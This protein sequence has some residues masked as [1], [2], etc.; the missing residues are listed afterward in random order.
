MLDQEQIDNWEAKKLSPMDYG[1]VVSGKKLKGS[2][3]VNG[4]LVMVM[5]AKQV[6]ASSKD[7]YVT[8][9]LFTVV[10]MVD[11][12]PAIPKQEND[13]VA[14]L[15]DPRSLEKVVGDE[16]AALKATLK[17]HYEGRSS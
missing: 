14:Y 17:T 1:R 3:L 15:I 12:L 8:R 2:G 5:G 4:D 7:P 13:Y 11:N 10:K 6:P 9:T 16:E